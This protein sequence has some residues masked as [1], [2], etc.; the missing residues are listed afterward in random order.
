[1]HLI[2]VLCTYLSFSIYTFTH[3]KKVILKL[4]QDLD[5][6]MTILRFC[7][8]ML[9][10]CFSVSMYNV[11]VEVCIPRFLLLID[12]VCYTRPRYLLTHIALNC[13]SVSAMQLVIC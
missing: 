7:L 13:L 5:V 12:V 10:L 9:C 1:M 3:F 8:F 11:P 6:H 4:N 2:R